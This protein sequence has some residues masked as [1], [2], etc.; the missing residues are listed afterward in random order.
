MLNGLAFLV[1]YVER[2]I[3]L[4]QT[5]R[6]SSI[7]STILEGTTTEG[8]LSDHY[9]P[10]ITLKHIRVSLPKNFIFFLF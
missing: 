1:S 4:T 8:T 9:N 10:P 5:Q 3:I 7:Y 2:G 6:Q